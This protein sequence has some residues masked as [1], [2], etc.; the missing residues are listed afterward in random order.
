MGPED[1]LKNWSD[2]LGNRAHSHDMMHNV[3]DID[4]LAVDEVVAARGVVLMGDCP[5]CPRQWKAVI[6]W[7][8]VAMMYVG[9][10]PRVEPPPWMP[11]RQA[12]FLGKLCRCS[13][14]HGVKPQPV[15]VEWSEVDQWVE[16][17]IRSG[18]LDPRIRQAR[19]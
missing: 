11:T 19:R 3:G 1:K 12:L 14:A 6:P 5:H 18:A 16:S 8:E 9:Q 17:G 10:V 7:G 15:R 4:G 2:G 13:L